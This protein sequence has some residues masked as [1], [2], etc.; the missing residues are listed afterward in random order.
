MMLNPDFEG[1]RAA[2]IGA[3]HE[4]TAAANNQTSNTSSP[5]PP[6]FS[7]RMWEYHLCIEAQSKPLL[8]R[9]MVCDRFLP[10]SI[11][12]EG[13]PVTRPI[14]DAR[15]MVLLY[16]RE[17]HLKAAGVPLLEVSDKEPISR[18]IATCTRKDDRLSGKPVKLVRKGK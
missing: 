11:F 1:G 8:F 5:N 4:K 15:G 9:C 14:P 10:W 18:F 13:K 2:Q 7:R 12:Y 17:S 3:G 6:V 16:T